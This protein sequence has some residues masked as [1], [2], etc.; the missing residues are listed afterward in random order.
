MVK[1]IDERDKTT[2]I[3]RR[4]SEMLG[5][6]KVIVEKFEL[7]NV[8]DINELSSPEALTLSSGKGEKRICCHQC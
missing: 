6:T 7:E 1:V 2:E 5:I 4:Y 8:V 3:K